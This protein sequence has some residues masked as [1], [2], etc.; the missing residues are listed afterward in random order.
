MNA[1]I[2]ALYILAGLVLGVSGVIL[3]V[4]WLL[5]GVDE[6]LANDIDA[7]SDWSNPMR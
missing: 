2:I 7:E 1:I 5:N 6:A 4:L 3:L